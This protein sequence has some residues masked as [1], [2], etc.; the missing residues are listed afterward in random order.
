MM[1]RVVTKLWLSLL[2]VTTCVASANADATIGYASEGGTG[3]V[4]YG[5]CLGHLE[6]T[7]T[8]GANDT[9]TAIHL[10]CHSGGASATFEAAVYTYSDGVPVSRVGDAV[11]HTFNSASYGWQTVSVSIP[12]SSGTE[13]TICTGE[14]AGSITLAR[15]A[16]SGG[17]TRR[18][19]CSSPPEL[20]IEDSRRDYLLSFYATVSSGEATADT[21]SVRRRKIMMEGE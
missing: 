18:D 21:V 2:I 6:Y 7:Y 12:L 19:G 9:V 11:S 17:M 3:Y 10:Y 16:I 4:F 20:W 1:N 13:Y 8:A 5:R 15:D 14:T